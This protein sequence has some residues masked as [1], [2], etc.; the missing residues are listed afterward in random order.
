M[1]LPIQK[2][3]QIP[4]NYFRYLPLSPELRLWGLGVT[5]AG[6]S[7]YPA[8]AAYPH[9]KHPD[10]HRFEWEHGRV[11][12]ALQIVLI[13][14][15]SG[16]LET[17]SSGKRHIKA[18][19]VFLLL[20]KTWHR[21]RPNANTGWHE[22]WIEIQGPVVN[23]LVQS[24]I[25]SPDSILLR[26]AIDAGLEEVMN[27]IHQRIRNG[28]AGFHPE[29]SAA[30][31]QVLSLCA[32]LTTTRPEPTCIQRAVNEAESYLSEHHAESVNIEALAKRLGVAYSHF[33]RAFLAQTGFAPWQY[34][35]HL[36]LTRARRML[37]SSNVK[38]DDVAARLGFSSGFHLSITFKKTYGQSPSAWRK[39]LFR[40]EAST[41][42]P[43]FQSV[44]SGNRSRNRKA[45]TA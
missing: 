24:G 40:S 43:D 16:T 42:I 22:S 27:A 5:A 32:R 18:G 36:R 2:M 25:F 38:L 33:R 30:A 15:G 11:L 3:P 45:R 7:R 19:M 4:T 35:I 29:L 1:T 34:V 41:E 9:A 17:R 44:E 6:F 10:D 23:E 12:D 31:L 28:P 13:T 21:Y 39:G 26:G 14:S 20:P 37:A 8:G